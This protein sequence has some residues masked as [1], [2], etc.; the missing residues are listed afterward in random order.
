MHNEPSGKSF[1]LRFVLMRVPSF[2]KHGERFATTRHRLSYRSSRAG[3]VLRP[4][5]GYEP[6]KAVSLRKDNSN[7]VQET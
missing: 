7:P 3:A 6:A 5:R 4:T 1:L 2:R